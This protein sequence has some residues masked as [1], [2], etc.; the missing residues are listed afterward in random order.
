MPINNGKKITDAS[1][2]EDTSL[3]GTEKFPIPAANKWSYVSSI[4]TYIAAAV[5]TLTNKT[6]NLTSNTLTGTTAQFNTA[7]SDNDFATLAGSETLTNKTLTTPTIGSFT[8]ATHTHTGA[9]S[10]GVVD[11]LAED[12]N[13]TGDISPSQITADQND[14][15]PTGLSTASTLR[16]NSDA[17]RNITG[18]SGG[19][20]GRVVL[21]YNV[22]SNNVVLKDESASSSAANRFALSGD[23][24]IAADEGAILQY[25]S[26]SSRWRCAGKAIAGGGGGVTGPGSSTDEA[27]AR[28]DGTGGSTL[29]NSAITISDTGAITF[30][31]NIRQTFNPGADASGL[32]VGAHA[33]DP[34]TPSNADLWYNSTSNQLKARVNGSTIVLSTGTGDVVGPASATD[35]AL[36]RFDSTTGKLIQNGAITMSDTGALTFPDN[37]RQT[38]NPGADAAG[39]NVGSIA[40]DPGTPSNGDLWYDSTAN[41]LTARINGSSVALG[42]GGGGRTLIA[43]V[44]P[45]GVTTV[46][47][48]SSISGSYKKLTLEFAIRS[49]QATNA[50]DGYIE[51]NTDTTAGN[52]RY[53]E[54]HRNAGGQGSGSGANRIFALTGI[55]AD[56][57]PAN[58]FAIGKIE[59]PQYANTNIQK[60]ALASFSM[61]YDASSVFTQVFTADVLWKNAAAIT[62]IDIALSAG[63]FASNSVIRLY[64]ES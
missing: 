44:T 6:I 26:T 11:T 41:E 39:L 7:L 51:F 48:A 21:I 32:N 42:A 38:F 4:L 54:I 10:G 12:L 62:Q 22:G 14:Y 2:T 52:Y 33:G 17:S 61:Q 13:L 18:L 34:G 45:T 64:G 59:I 46:T 20:D 50:V 40:G 58:G 30:P 19:A 53:N 9:A 25:D 8:N 37:V 31:D 28:F 56:S 15:N 24:T 57:A 49:T 36:A 60:T 47:V 23:I 63:N 27:V 16:L 35:E 1:I 29:Q 5:A 55:S 3:D 43:E